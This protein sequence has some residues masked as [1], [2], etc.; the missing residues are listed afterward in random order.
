MNQIT[1]RMTAGKA[2]PKDIDL[3]LSVSK[4]IQGKCLCPLGEF[5]TMAVVSGIQ[6]FRPDFEALV[7]NPAA[8]MP[9]GGVE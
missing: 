9:V 7:S 1:R 3:L 2:S 6:S 4:Q 5:S 8:V